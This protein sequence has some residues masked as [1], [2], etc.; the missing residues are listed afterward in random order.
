MACE[1]QSLEQKLEE[2]QLKER[3]GEVEKAGD[4][5]NDIKEYV[6]AAKDALENSSPEAKQKVEEFCEVSEAVSE[7]PE[8]TAAKKEAPATSPKDA[9]QDSEGGASREVEIAKEEV[10]K[11]PDEEAYSVATVEH[12]SYVQGEGERKEDVKTAVVHENADFKGEQLGKAGILN[13][14]AGKISQSVKSVKNA[15]SSIAGSKSG[16]D[17]GSKNEED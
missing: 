4:E 7:I 5:A 13:S 8:N 16:K 6:D 11:S 2:L 10:A 3:Q 14:V 17:L 15:L 9:T 1:D 12:R